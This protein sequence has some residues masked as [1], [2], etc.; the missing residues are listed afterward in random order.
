LFRHVGVEPKDQKILA[1]KSA[2][3]FR[4]EFEPMSEAVIVVIAPG[5]HIVDPREY[6][7]QRLRGGVRLG[8]LGPE[9]KPSSQASA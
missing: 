9:F 1:L 3:H 5:G 6:A 4:A 8:P 2:V 7:Y